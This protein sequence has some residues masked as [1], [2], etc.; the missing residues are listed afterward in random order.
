M[1][2]TFPKLSISSPWSMNII[3][4]RQTNFF[5]FLV[6]PPIG[7]NRD[8]PNNVIYPNIPI[9]YIIYDMLLIDFMYKSM[10][11]VPGAPAGAFVSWKIAY[12]LKI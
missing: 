11:L 2:W 3:S 7:I 12:F 6:D 1:E 10:V 4:I 9:N 5:A 8:I